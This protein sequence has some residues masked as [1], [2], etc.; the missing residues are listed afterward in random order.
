MIE[1]EAS[2]FTQYLVYALI[3][4]PVVASVLMLPFKGGVGRK[5]ITYFFAGLIAVG[6]IT[7][8][9]TNLGTMTVPIEV[10]ES[11]TQIC[12]YLGIAVSVLITLCI[13]YYGI[14]HKNILAIILSVI[15]CAGSLYIEFVIAPNY[16]PTSNLYIDSL[17][18]LMTFIIG[19]IGSGICVY[20]LGYMEDHNK[21]LK[22]GEK[23]RSNIFFALMFLFLSAMFII[24]FSNNMLWM[25]AGWE[26]TT[27]CSFL[28]I[29]YTKTPEAIKNSFTQINMNLLG[30]ITFAGALYLSATNFQT[31]Q[32]DV[33]ISS[34]IQ[35][36]VLVSLPVFLLAISAITKAAQMP[37]HKWLLGAMVA[38][39]PTS[40]LLHSSTMVK[41]GVFLLLKLS[42]VFFTMTNLTGT[43]NPIYSA[44]AMMVMLVGGV[45]FLFCSFMAISQSNAKR[46][47]AYSTI[48]NLGLITTCAGI[49]TPFAIWAAIFLLLFHAC[50]K[51]LLFLCVGTAEHHIGSR[52]IEDMDALFVRM[53]RLARF[54]IVGMMAMFIA[55]FGMLISKWAALISFID[56]NQIA[57]ILI[58][59]FGSA[60]TFMFWAKWIGKL[61]GIVLNKDNIEKAVHKSEWIAQIIMVVL[62]IL[63]LVLLP[64]ISDFVVLPQVYTEYS[65]L[66]QQILY[67]IVYSGMLSSPLSEDCIFVVIVSLIV[68]AIVLF[69]GIG[70]KNK[71]AQANIYL[72]GASVDNDKRLYKGSMGV[73]T[74]A[75]SR[76][77]Y[78]LS[79][80]DEVKL[81][82]IGS[83]LN[84]I[85]MVLAG[86]AAAL[87]MAGV[88]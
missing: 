52:N 44:P 16:E 7:L 11:A 69:A 42:P 38:P 56:S 77:W 5:I 1:N 62:L 9:V 20:A 32:L 30:G 45:T 59:A 10:P 19:V 24:V 82:P 78:M 55:P 37:F 17:T 74:K 85:L 46:V 53:P 79:L 8:V 3:A 40:A 60:A 29:G 67:Q 47:L 68:V 63:A 14:K 39:T 84:I 64:V 12:S 50:A 75:T 31:L 87:L 49:G 73:D 35:N 81:S 58:L 88:L 15:Q 76:N 36:V 43:K 2:N 34:G 22:D 65:V 18:L 48:A 51:S 83:I 71:K 27:V 57:L 66:P 61:T 23:N 86:V 70:R 4:L 21:H 54:M 28:L 33:F 26:L 80:F 72:A 25:F 41:A 13:L 6:S